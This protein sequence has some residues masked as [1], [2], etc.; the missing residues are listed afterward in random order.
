[1]LEVFL[2]FVADDDEFDGVA[3]DV[4]F[5][6]IFMDVADVGNANGKAVDVG[7]SSSFSGDEQESEP[8]E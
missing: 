7:G 4:E 5:V 2:C 1:M 8:D 3:D 6:V